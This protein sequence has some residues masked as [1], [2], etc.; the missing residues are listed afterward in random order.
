MNKALVAVSKRIVQTAAVAI[1]AVVIV[2]I[3]ENAVAN[4]N[5]E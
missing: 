5:N 2:K 3:V 1:A 4:A